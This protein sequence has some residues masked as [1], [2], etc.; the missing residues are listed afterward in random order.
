MYQFIKKDTA[1]YYVVKTQEQQE[2]E[3]E[4]ANLISQ[5]PM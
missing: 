1:E 5:G 3:Y 4:Q 2:E